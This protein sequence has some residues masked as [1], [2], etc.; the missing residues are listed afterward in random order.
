MNHGSARVMPAPYRAASQHVNPAQ[1]TVDAAQR[2]AVGI[3]GFVVYR[4]RE[5]RAMTRA[6]TIWRSSVNSVVDRRAAP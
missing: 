5:T 6:K 4:F 2:D 3:T 1:P